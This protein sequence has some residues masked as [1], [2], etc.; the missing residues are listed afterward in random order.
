[1]TFTLI[2][3]GA[4]SPAMLN[5][6]W[7]MPA[8]AVLYGSEFGNG[9]KAWTE[10]ITTILPPPPRATMCRAA[11]W[12]QWNTLHMATWSTVWNSSSVYSRNGFRMLKAALLIR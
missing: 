1:M 11:A 4:S 6:V 7:L 9:M 8:F 3:W 12:E 5:A 10:L 2:R